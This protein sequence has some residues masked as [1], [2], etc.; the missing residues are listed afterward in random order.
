M[1]VVPFL[2]LLLPEYLVMVLWKCR[3]SARKF[4]NQVI[5]GH[6]FVVLL[7]FFLSCYCAE[8]EPHHPHIWFYREWVIEVV[9]DNYFLRFFYRNRMRNKHSFGIGARG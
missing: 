8:H 2:A 3:L 9:V 5:G 7:K 1:I 6:Q 4:L